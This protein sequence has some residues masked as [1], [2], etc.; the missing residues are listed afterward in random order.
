MKFVESDAKKYARFAVSME[1][2]MNLGIKEFITNELQ[3]KDFATRQDLLTTKHELQNSFSELKE[4]VTHSLNELESKFD[5]KFL[6]FEAKMEKNTKDIVL[7]IVTLMTG[8]IGAAVA[9]IK[10]L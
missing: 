6:Q 10:L 4:S 7:L 3:M 1:R 8:I 2:R 9:V 5:K